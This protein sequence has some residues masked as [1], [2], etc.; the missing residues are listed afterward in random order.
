M[1][2]PSLHRERKHFC[3]YCLQAFRTEEMLRF[4]TNDCFK[5]NGKQ[6]KVNILD[7]KTMKEKKSHHL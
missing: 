1:Y 2:D 6:N 4:H 5:T 3:R 7:S